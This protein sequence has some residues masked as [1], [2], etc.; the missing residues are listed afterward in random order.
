MNALRRLPPLATTSVGSLPFTSPTEAGRHAARA[1]TV[2]FCPQLPRLDGDMIREWLG[3]DPAGCGWNPDRDRQRP[4]AWDAFASEVAARPPLHRVVKLQVTGPLTLAC[5][6][7]RSGRRRGAGR[8]TLALAGEIAR[9]LAVSV[10]EQIVA[11][12]ELGLDALLLVDEPGLAQLGVTARDVTVW[13]PLR[14]AS[15]AAWGLHICGTVPW[16]LVDGAD[17]D[18]LSY[19]LTRDHVPPPAR[20]VITRLLA[21]GGRIAW[22][23][24]DPVSPG[25]TATACARLA[26]A[27]ASLGPPA[28][29]VAAASLVTPTCGTGRLAPGRERLV[30]ATLDAAIRVTAGAIAAHGARKLA[31]RPADSPA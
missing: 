19:N 13:D 22:G 4:A 30:A 10:R 18:L 12:R 8:E 15:A 1:Y 28:A 5:A 11:L 14:F 3:A 24:I 23:A 7:E 6:L 27:I 16:T 20:P 26:A 25:D 17:P 9:W 21:R 2:P 31:P 29:D